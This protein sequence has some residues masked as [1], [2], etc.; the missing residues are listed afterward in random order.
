MTLRDLEFSEIAALKDQHCFSSDWSKIRVTENFS[1]DPIYNVRFKGEVVIGKLG[2]GI[3]SL[4][5]EE[6]IS[7]LFNCTISQCTIGND[8]L[9]EDVH[10]VENYRIM[11]QVILENVDTVRVRGRSSFGN[12][13]EIGVLNEGGG[14][15]LMMFDKLNAQLAFMLVFYRHEPALINALSNMIR[16]YSSMR[17]SDTGN[18]GKGTV[19]INAGTISNVEIGEHVTIRSTTLLENGTIVSNVY[20]PVLIGEGVVAR[21]FIVQSGSTV[22]GAALLENCFVG[23]SVEMGKQFSAENSVFF[24][25]SEAFH[26]EAVSVF[27]G[28][29]TVT[30]HKSTLLIAG[31]FS[32]FNGGSGTN[33]SNHMYKLGPVH[34]GV[35]ER[36]SKTGSFAYMLWPSRV[37]AFSVVMGKNMTRFDTSDFP[38]SYITVEHE[39]SI[40]TPGMNLF[41]VGTRRDSEKW[42][43]R[44]KRK[45]PETSD[46]INFELLSPYIIQKVLRSLDI[47]TGLYEKTSR[48]Q[49]SVYYKGIRIK[50]LMLKSTRKYYEMALAIFIGNQVMKKLE[51]MG[52]IKSMVA[53]REA[54]SS[55]LG[56]ATDRWMD[57]AGMIAPEHVILTLIGDI[58]AGTLQSLEEISTVLGRIHDDYDQYAWDW[59]IKILSARYDIDVGI[60][61]TEQLLDLLSKWASDSLKLDQMILNDAA[62][63]YDESSRIGFGIDGDQSVVDKDFEIVR[64]IPEK[65]KFIIGIKRDMEQI[66]QRAAVMT[67]LLCRL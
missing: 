46:L 40:L 25:N 55:G 22:D 57:L 39:K 58:K 48:K 47:L 65:N 26:G 27:A 42:P 20:A 51:H 44:D 7:G 32:F 2:G 23:Q 60:I 52:E 61:E 33:Q 54:L 64:G 4:E 41:T 24:A 1:S 34:Q 36:G 18:I 13:K 67:K 17:T 19:I 56:S 66:E 35:V 12:G 28:P 9:I 63:E 30:H 14:R 59:T 43:S 38:F 8:V 53:L 21:N 49:E 5:G 37:G 3:S 16:E 6:R 11:D 15:E 50:R 62:K 45:D 29:Y 10:L 31:M